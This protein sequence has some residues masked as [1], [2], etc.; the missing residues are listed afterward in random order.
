MDGITRYTCGKCGHSWVP[1]VE[2]PDLCPKCKSRHWKK[3]AT[4]EVQEVKK[5]EDIKAIPEPRA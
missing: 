4:R 5:D 2:D 1:R 3:A